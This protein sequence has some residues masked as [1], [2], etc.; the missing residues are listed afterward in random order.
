MNKFSISCVDPAAREG[1]V[2]EASIGCCRAEQH[3]QHGVPSS[4]RVA[5][6]VTGRES[7]G[8]V[9]GGGRCYRAHHGDTDCSLAIPVRTAR[10][11]ARQ[12]DHFGAARVQPKNS[13]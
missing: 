11:H 13:N 6:G 9:N 12:K 2:E 1:L 5:P 4:G 7:E 10:L 8:L 3:R